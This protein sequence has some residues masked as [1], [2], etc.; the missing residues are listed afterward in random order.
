MSIEPYFLSICF[1]ILD[2]LLRSQ[3]GHC[4]YRLNHFFAIIHSGRG[5][6]Y[7]QT[8]HFDYAEPMFPNQVAYC[9]VKC[10]LHLAIKTVTT[11]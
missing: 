11:E 4:L 5:I 9:C 7:D 6:D 8:Y 3:A 1:R 10:L 2:D